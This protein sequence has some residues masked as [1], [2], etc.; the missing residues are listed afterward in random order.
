MNVVLGQS[1]L[2]I[3]LPENKIF[4]GGGA[5]NV[6]Y[7]WTQLEVPFTL[8][9]RIAADVSP[10]FL[11]FYRRHGVQ[12]MP[13]N[14]IQDGQSGSSDITIR[15][16]GEVYMDN[17][18]EGIG[19]DIKLNEAEINLVAQANWLH[20]FLIKSI[21]EEIKRL[22]ESGYLASTGVSG[23][24]FDFSPFGLTSFRETMQ[25]IDIGF[26]GWQKELTDRT[27]VE[28]KAIV[29]DLEKMLVV[30][31]GSRGVMV[32]DGRPNS[33]LPTMAGSLAEKLFSVEPLPVVGTTIGCGDAFAAYF[34]AEWWKSHDISNAVH[35]GKLGGSQ[36]TRWSR[37]LPDVAYGLGE[38]Y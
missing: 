25:Y 28:I 21:R 31:L 18:V 35:A 36:A 29:R 32:Y 13:A 3:Y 4:P 10:H 38:S 8:L 2:D 22:A 23:D 17:W 20:A 19:A 12:L 15:P 26:I 14:L 1:D 9:S 34:L 27:M 33:P 11:E 30:T 6:S 7:H 24:F 16:D 5:L 37:C